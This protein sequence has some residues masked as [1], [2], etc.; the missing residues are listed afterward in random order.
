MSDGFYRVVDKL[1]EERDALRV[2]VKE[3]EGERDALRRELETAHNQ[4]DMYVPLGLMFRDERDQL[5]N[6]LNHLTEDT[7]DNEAAIKEMCARVVGRECVEGDS[8]GVP[9]IVTCVEKLVERHGELA[10]ERDHLRARVATLMRIVEFVHKDEICDRVGISTC[11]ELKKLNSSVDQC[12][13]C[14]CEDALS[15]HAPPVFTAEQV[16]PIAQAADEVYRQFLIVDGVNVIGVN[17]DWAKGLLGPAVT[18]ARSIGLL[19][20]KR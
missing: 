18:H 19:E 16:R 17:P 6:K 2:K 12:I 5:R 13:W 10:K 4:V 7:C 1:A 11:N 8:Y 15:T 3:V 14:Q 9:G 20:D